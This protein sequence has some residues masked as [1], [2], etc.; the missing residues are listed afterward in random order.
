M[1]GVPD[2]LWD[3]GRSEAQVRAFYDGWADHYDADMDASGMLGP[4]RVADALRRFVA[5][6]AP[7]LD[8]GC[9]TGACGAALRA[10]GFGTVHGV[11]L[12]AAMLE[13]ARARDAY[14]T[15][16]LAEPDAAV[17]VPEGVGGV[18]A[19]GSISVGAG[20][21]RLL[22]DLLGAMSAGAVLVLTYNDDTLRQA[23]YMRALSDAQVDG[24]ARLAWAEHGIQ[25][26]ALGRGATVFALRRL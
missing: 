17:T 24:A 19:C 4:R 18:A 5:P 7:I 14:A 25:L 15:L 1:T 16:T 12:S 13:R 8:F 6:D 23:D 21:A 10:A 11:D 22:P 3:P 2:D 26:P 20:P 9:G